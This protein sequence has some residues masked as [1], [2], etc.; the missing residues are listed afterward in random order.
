MCLAAAQKPRSVLRIFPLH[1][2]VVFS[3]ER[4]ERKRETERKGGGGGILMRL[5]EIL[6]VTSAHGPFLLRLLFCAQ[7][8]LH[9]DIVLKMASR[10]CPVESTS[11]LP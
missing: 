7:L 1:A 10:A 2:P 9:E 4:K 6:S 5:F 3:A 8:S 11:L